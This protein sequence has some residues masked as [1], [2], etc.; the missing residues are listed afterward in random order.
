MPIRVQTGTV[1]NGEI[2]LVTDSGLVLSGRAA[3]SRRPM[4]V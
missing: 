3:V 4:I 1:T 2:S